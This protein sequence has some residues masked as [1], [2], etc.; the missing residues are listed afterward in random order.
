[1]AKIFIDLLE[2][3]KAIAH[4]L[5]SPKT[6]N[7]GIL[8]ISYTIFYVVSIIFYANSVYLFFPTETSAY[9]APAIPADP[10]DP[11]IVGAK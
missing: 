8:L 10:L 5:G 6:Y 7:S 9:Q 3:I 2:L 4:I 11:A 1:M